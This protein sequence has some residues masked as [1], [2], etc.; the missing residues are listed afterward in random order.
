M[1]NTIPSLG[2]FTTD[3][4]LSVRTWDSW[5]SGVTDLS[6]EDVRGK[7]L[8]DII[9]DLESRGLAGKF[10]QV[11]NQGTVEVLAPLFHRYLIA[12]ASMAPSRHFNHMR[13]RVTIMPLRDGDRISGALVSVED[14]TARLEAERMS[15]GPTTNPAG[16]ATPLIRAIGDPSWRVRREAVR[17][18]AAPKRRRPFAHPTVGT[19]G[20]RGAQQCTGGPFHEPGRCVAGAAGP[21]ERSRW[22]SQVRIYVAQVLGGQSIGRSLGCPLSPYLL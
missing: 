6:L 15:D 22:G 4:N 8:T 21:H 19:P 11:L 16:D 14:V 20:F 12:C 10:R 2:I 13:Q 3:E 17:G 1:D 5:L 7:C 18:L 9:P